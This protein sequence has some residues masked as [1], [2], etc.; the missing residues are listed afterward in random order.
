MDS[1]LRQ[2][3]GS[4]STLRKTGRKSINFCGFSHTVTSLEMFISDSV[5]NCSDCEDNEAYN[6]R[7]ST[8]SSARC[9]NICSIFEILCLLSTLSLTYFCQR[10]DNVTWYDLLENFCSEK[11]LLDYFVEIEEYWWKIWPWPITFTKSLQEEWLQSPCRNRR[12]TSSHFQQPF[13]GF[14]QHW[15]SGIHHSST[16]MKIRTKTSSR[17]KTKTSTGFP[18]TT[19]FLRALIL[20]KKNTTVIRLLEKKDLLRWCELHEHLNNEISQKYTVCQWK[21]DSHIRIHSSVFHGH[22][23]VRHEDTLIRNVVDGFQGDEW[24]IG[25][26]Q[27]ETYIETIQLWTSRISMMEKFSRKSFEEW[28]ERFSTKTPNNY[29]FFSPPLPR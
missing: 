6:L 13:K 23:L 28:Q 7:L 24:L 17:I 2:W 8:S 21:E 14:S 10:R 20:Q 3:L 16:T 1:E 12:F 15:K 4:V 22:A 26:F 5:F 27:E 11:C 18:M 19:F 9:Y 29:V 25:P